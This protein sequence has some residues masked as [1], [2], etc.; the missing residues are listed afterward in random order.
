MAEQETIDSTLTGAIEKAV[1]T[2]KEELREDSK[3]NA[4]NEGEKTADSSKEG[5]EDKSSSEDADAEQGKILIQAL[6]DPQKAE[7]V[8]DFLARKAGYTKE[9]VQTK[10]DVKEA[11]ADIK[12]ILEK[13]LGDDFKFLAPAL[14]P[15]IKETL[16]NLLAE[17]GIESNKDLRARVEKQELKDIQ[18]E[19]VKAHLAISQ[20]WFGSDDM[21]QN[22]IK[23]MS[24]AMDEFPPTDPNMSPERYYKRIFHLVAGE[25]GLTKKGSSASSKGDKV[26][27]NSTDSAARNL[28]SQNRGVTPN[29]D[30]NPRKMSLNDAVKQAMETVSNKK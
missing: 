4:N 5:E 26:S 19:T 11:R 17:K 8:I 30:G 29:P 12:S 20:E 21:P 7:L 2:H 6:R 16:D 23:A 18:N 25:L 10:Q 22:V 15:A 13:T 28:T 14:A 1:E 27:R 3:D 24:S 9:T